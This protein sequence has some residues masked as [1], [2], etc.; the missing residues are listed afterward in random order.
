MLKKAQEVKNSQV[1][2]A[3][4]LESVPTDKGRTMV[5]ST[6]FG[7][8]IAHDEELIVLAS[9]LNDKQGAAITAIPKQFIKKLV[10]MQGIEVM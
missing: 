9:H 8:V 3:V 4:W 10:I 2:E 5:E 7:R 6:T 1:I